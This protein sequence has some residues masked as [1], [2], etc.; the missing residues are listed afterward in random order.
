VITL[1]TKRNLKVGGKLKCFLSLLLYFYNWFQE[2]YNNYI[3]KKWKLKI[4]QLRILKL[5]VKT[6]TGVRIKRE[7]LSVIKQEYSVAHERLFPLIELQ[8]MEKKTEGK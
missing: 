3:N 5:S 7:S 4:D 8:H 6:R 1:N 2:K